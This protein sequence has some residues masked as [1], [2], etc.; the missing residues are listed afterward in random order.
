LICHNVSCI[1][2]EDHGTYLETSYLHAEIQ[3]AL[4]ELFGFYVEVW[5]DRSKDR[6]IKATAFTSYKELDLFIKVIDLTEYIVLISLKLPSLLSSP[7]H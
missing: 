3:V 2:I 1:L 7:N 5:L 4:F 6:L